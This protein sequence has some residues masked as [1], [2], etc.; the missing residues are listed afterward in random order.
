MARWTVSNY[1]KK[2]TIDDIEEC[3]LLNN[4]FRQCFKISRPQSYYTIRW[5]DIQRPDIL[6]YKL[7][8]T[9]DLWWILYKH[10]CIDDI[11]N[12][13]SEGDV[14]AVPHISDIEDFYVSAQKFS[15]QL[16]K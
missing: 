15:N 12:D 7:Y 6:S 8:G 11:W 1:Y 13:L 9:P 4:Y 3:D 2:E 14:I 10:N 16:S 5:Q